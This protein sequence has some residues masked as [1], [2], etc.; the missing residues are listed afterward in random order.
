MRSCGNSDSQ[1]PVS[2]EAAA[3]SGTMMNA[4]FGDQYDYPPIEGSPRLQLMIASI[5]RSG[6]TAFCND[7]WNTGA[8]GAP[9][10][11]LN[12]KWLEKQ[13]RWGSETRDLLEYWRA[14]Q[15]VR[16]S[17]NGVFSYKMF[18]SNY[19]SVL[20][21]CPALLPLLAP[22]HVVYLSRNDLVAQAVSYARAIKSQQWF[23]SGSHR[24]MP[25]YDKA[26]IDDARR[27]ILKQA[28]QWER[29]FSLTEADV[30][31]V[32]YE[33]YLVDRSGTVGRVMQYVCGTSET[34]GELGLPN[35]DIQ[36]DIS[37][38]EWVERYNEEC[39]QA[40]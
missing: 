27:L 20:E 18:V 40:V 1:S 39:A 3:L 2:T 30:L 25:E 10:E 9:T 19:F 31:R 8:L 32:S 5:P 37:S 26:L 14:L 15:T 11:Y 21:R 4:R 6:S 23:N 17:P 38:Y 7:L 22:T 24:I 28:Q 35:I 16:T 12:L 13:G 29:I 34:S 36:R 33:E